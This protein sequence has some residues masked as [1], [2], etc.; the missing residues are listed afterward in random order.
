MHRPA[1]Q[2]ML[3]TRQY[4]S[5]ELANIWS[6]IDYIP[7]H[8]FKPLFPLDPVTNLPI[9]SQFWMDRGRKLWIR[10][11]GKDHVEARRSNDGPLPENLLNRFGR[12]WSKY[13]IYVSCIAYDSM[14]FLWVEFKKGR[15]CRASLEERMDVMNLKE[16]WMRLWDFARSKRDLGFFY[17]YLESTVSR[18][19]SPSRSA[20]EHAN[21]YCR[22]ANDPSPVDLDNPAT[23]LVSQHYH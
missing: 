2:P 19:I 1:I 11:S 8:K 23:N 15:G 9:F 6:C 17:E 12:V 3:M 20:L 16:V 7:R 18:Q 22:M 14:V 21:R 4:T 13:D 5:I 10:L